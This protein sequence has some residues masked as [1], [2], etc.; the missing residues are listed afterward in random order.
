MA[1]TTTA[2]TTAKKETSRSGLQIARI[3]DQYG[4]LVI[5]AILFLLASMLIPNFA[6]MINMKG[7][8]L[9]VAWS[10]VACCSVW[11]LANLICRSA[12][13]SP[14]PASLVRSPLMRLKVSPW[15]CWQV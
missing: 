1:I 9:A 13:S 5:F 11:L 8:G 2:Q 10:P 4:M 6:S 12:P 3:W 15:G 7:L 14:V